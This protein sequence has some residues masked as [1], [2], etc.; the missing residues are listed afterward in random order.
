MLA[1]RL[2]MTL[3]LFRVVVDAVL[4]IINVPAVI[5]PVCAMAPAAE[6]VNV[7]LPALTAAKAMVVPV[8]IFIAE[9]FELIVVPA[10]QLIVEGAVVWPIFTAPPVVISPL[11]A[12]TPDE[13]KVRASSATVVPTAPRVTPPEPFIM[14]RLSVLAVVPLTAF[15]PNVTALLWVAVMIISV[16]SF[17]PP[18]HPLKT[19]PGA[20]PYI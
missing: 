1:P 16:L 18:V 13:S 20:P 10:V 11:S 4:V 12:T 2:V 5:T 6:S 7:L 3:A 19:T 14:V 8:V 17:M 15:D 9:L